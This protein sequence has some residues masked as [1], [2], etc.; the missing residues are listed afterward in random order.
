MR[1][2][3]AIEPEHRL[4]PHRRLVRQ[5]HRAS[6]GSEQTV[7]QYHRSVVAGVP[8]R[9]EGLGCDHEGVLRFRRMSTEIR[10]AL[11]PIPIQ[12]YCPAIRNQSRIFFSESLRN[13]R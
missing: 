4:L 2:H 9:G 11:H 1:P 13:S 10:L 6:A 8:V 5:Q 7:G 3:E 12:D